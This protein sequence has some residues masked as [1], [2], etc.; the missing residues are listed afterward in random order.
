MIRFNRFT[1]ARGARTLFEDTTFS[2]N[3]G[4][5]AGLIGTNG[6]GKSTLFAT[7][8]GDLQSDGGEVSV[9]PNWQIAHVAQHTESS[10]RRALDYALDGDTVLRAAE[11]RIAAAAAAHDG[12]AEAY[13]HAAYADADGYTAEARAQALLMGL[14][15]TLEETS[16]PVASFSG[17][18]RMRLNLAQALMCR[19]DLLLLDEPTNH[20]DLDAIVWLEDWLRRYPGTLIVISHDREF[21]D[22][23]CNV[24]LHIDDKHVIRYGGN[25]SQ[26]EVTRS[27][28]LAYH[29]SAYEKQQKTVEHLQSFVDRFKTK[30][31]KARQAQSRIKMLERMQMLAPIYAASPFTFSFREPDRAPNPLLV[32]DDLACGYQDDAGTRTEILRSVTLSVQIGQRIGLLGANGQGKSTLIKTLADELAPL[33]G[34]LVAGKGMKIGYFA[35]HQLETLVPERSPLGHMMKLAPD[36]REQELRDFLGSFNF[37]GD[38]ALNPIAPLSGGEKARLALAL[39]V[40]Q[41]P[42]LLLLDEPTNHLDLDTREALTQALAQ[43]DGTMIIVSHD[44]HLLRAVSDEFMLVAD[45]KLGPFDGDLDDYRVWLLANAQARRTAAVAGAAATAAS[46]ASIASDTTTPVLP[47]SAAAPAEKISTKG[48]GASKNSNGTPAN[49]SANSNASRI[50]DPAA[51]RDKRRNDASARQALAALR[52][53][54]QTRIAALERDLKSLQDERA[55]LDAWIAAPSSYEDAARTQ[56]ADAL[57]RHGE[58]AA[59]IDAL[60]TDWLSA[61]EELARTDA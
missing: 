5:K 6:S 9:P 4:E 49:A 48:N 38:M 22:A 29:Q 47:Q 33:S 13:A 24:T 1:L 23:I 17:G 39:I 58:V 43:F 57:K 55:T 18:W 44:R 51:R 56:L 53:P 61:H 11:A 32:L 41:K 42:N 19:S 46:T 3:P 25:Y 34:K 21:L 28:R 15:F 52:K 16:H 59:R 10:Q 26:F 14:G 40:W 50:D 7:L 31:S 60:E 30:A 35:Q 8:T 2:L 27:Q 54:I 45:H 12:E 37:R 20:L 36:V